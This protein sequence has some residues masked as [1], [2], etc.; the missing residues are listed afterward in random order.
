MNELNMFRLFTIL[1]LLVLPLAC[2][3]NESSNGGDPGPDRTALSD[4]PESEGSPP[5]ETQEPADVEITTTAPMT[6]EEYAAACGQ[7]FSEVEARSSAMENMLYD[8]PDNM[9]L[10]ASEAL[11]AMNDS[12]DAFEDSLNTMTTWNPPE[13]LRPF[14]ELM[15]R[16]V[17]LSREQLRSGGLRDLLEETQE[18]LSSS[19]MQ[20]LGRLEEGVDRLSD[21]ET[22]EDIED[23]VLD[24]LEGDGLFQVLDGVT[25][26][27]DGSA[28]ADM[29]QLVQIGLRLEKELE[30]MEEATAPLEAEAIQVQRDLSPETIDV[31]VSAGC[32]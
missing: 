29:G 27:Q 15:M 10:A 12:I 22:D 25:A 7:L 20:G 26:I 2:T 9:V 4:S 11:A 17:E 3:V 28:I 13:E 8:N 14:H 18:V 21:M 31:L 1:I 19:G 32:M 24:S 30:K 6:V 23:Y 5:A 16:Y